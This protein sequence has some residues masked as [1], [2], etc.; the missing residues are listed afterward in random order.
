M[1]PPCPPVRAGR[2]D[3]WAHDGP[4]VVVLT[5]GAG[6]LAIPVRPPQG[7]GRFGHLAHFLADPGRWHK[8]DLVRYQ[9]PAAPGGWRY[10]A[11]L[12]IIGV[13]YASPATRRRRAQVARLHRRGED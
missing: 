11:H 6:E 13:G 4:L 1:S 7:S 3:W 12:M 2:R 9:D 5:G 8:I 10:Q